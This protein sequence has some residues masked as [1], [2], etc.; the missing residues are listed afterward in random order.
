MPGPSKRASHLKIISGTDRNGT[1]LSTPPVEFPHLE[2]VPT[3]PDWLPNAHAVAEWKRLAPILVVNKML[4]EAD[5]SA[6]AHLCAVHGKLVQLWSAGEAP[7][8]HL[9][10][11]YNSLASA[12]GI[13]P[14]WRA[15]V[16]PIGAKNESNK[17]SKISSAPDA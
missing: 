2:D 3:P 1:R 4:A 16:K 11:Q 12:F 10:N 7:T 5:L 6:F 14:A 17:F 15:K 9:L 13:S 8:G